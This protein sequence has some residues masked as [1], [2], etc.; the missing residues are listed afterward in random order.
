MHNNNNNY[1]YSQVLSAIIFLSIIIHVSQSH[2]WRGFCT[3]SASI[4]YM[5]Y[6]N[7]ILNLFYSFYYMSTG[8]L[9]HHKRSLTHC[10]QVKRLAFSTPFLSKPLWLFPKFFKLLWLSLDFLSHYAC[11][12]SC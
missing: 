8:W 9:T 3:M 2:L 7:F 1:Y 11:T 10:S 6:F 12:C 5:I 4:I